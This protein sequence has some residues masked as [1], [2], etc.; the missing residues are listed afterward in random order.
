MLLEGALSRNISVSNRPEV[1]DRKYNVDFDAYV[2]RRRSGERMASNN[3]KATPILTP[4]GLR[5]GLSI[6]IEMKPNEE[7][8]R[9]G[10]ES[11]RGISAILI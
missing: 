1:E 11:R 6:G 9:C 5:I 7:M 2:E 3:L 10:G 4:F 8:V